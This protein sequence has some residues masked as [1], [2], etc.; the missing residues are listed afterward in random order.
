M[1]R[2]L[3]RALS[4]VMS[5]AIALSLMVFVAPV[6]T[7]AEDYSSLPGYPD[8]PAKAF[9]GGSPSATARL[10][11]LNSPGGRPWQDPSLPI[12]WRVQLLVDCMTLEEKAGQTIQLQRDATQSYIQT[13]YLGSILSGGGSVPSPNTPAGWTTMMNNIQN[14]AAATPLQIPVLYQIDA[15]H[16]TGHMN[17]NNAGAHTT[18]Y[19]HNYQAANIAGGITDLSSPKLQSTIQ[20]LKDYYHATAEEMRAIGIQGS[21]SP[22]VCTP[23]NYRWGRTHE[24]WNNDPLYNGIMAAAC[25]EGMQGGRPV[26]YSA[27]NTDYDHPNQFPFLS[28]PD[29]AIVCMKHF[30]GEGYT[31]NGANTGNMIIPSLPTTTAALKALTTEQLKAMPIIQELLVPYKLLVEAGARCFMP[32]YSSIN[33]LKM[34]EFGPMQDL[35]K[36]PKSEGG[37]GFTGFVVSDYNAHTNG[38]TG[39]NQAARN[40]NCFNAGVDLAMVVSA[41]ECTSATGWYQTMISNVNSGAVTVARL[42]DAV[43]RIL[44]VKFEQGLFDT[45]GGVQF[46]KARANTALQAT[47]R[48][49]EHVALAR[50]MVRESLVLLKNDPS[51]WDTLQTVPPNQILVAGT[52]A[53]DIGYQVGSWVASWQGGSSTN[54]NTYNGRMIIDAV[55]DAKGTGVLYNASG[56]VTGTPADVKVAIVCIGETSYAEGSGDQT[57]ITTASAAATLQFNDTYLAQVQSVKTNY[58]NAK[59]IV[60]MLSG[61][62]MVISGW[63]DSVDAIIMC[64]WFGTEAGG[65][66]DLLFDPN[67][68]FTGRSAWAWP[69]G[70]QTLGDMS[71]PPLFPIGFGL[72]KNQETPPLVR[73]D[74]QGA[75]ININASGNTS[76]SGTIYTQNSTTGVRTYNQKVYWKEG[77]ISSSTLV[78]P[79]TRGAMATG[80]RSTYVEYKLYIQRP[81]AYTFGYTGSGTSAGGLTLSMDGGDGVTFNAAASVSGVSMGNLTPGEHIMRITFNTNTAMTLTTLSVTAPGGAALTTVVPEVK[82]VVAGFNANIPVATNAE[83]GAI[84]K[85][86]KGSAVIGEAIVAD[87]KAVVALKKADLS[88]AGTLNAVVYVEGE[89]QIA[90]PISVVAYDPS[91]WTVKI[92]G[93][94]NSILASFNANID[95]S[96]AAFD[97]KVNGVSV[98]GAKTSVVGSDGKSFVINGAQIDFLNSGDEF[99]I[100]GVRLPDMFPDYTFT[101]RAVLVK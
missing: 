55:R 95:L 92:S 83:D 76:W 47:I 39:A 77:Y 72:T 16:G 68:D 62:P 67:Y 31:Y 5:V 7:S 66:A 30:F 54:Y 51:I 6:S 21:F 78:S 11:A 65:V 75:P 32:S 96:S 93:T 43:S 4:L 57:N 3:R 45:I 36:K 81:G 100:I 85:I 20:L 24:G 73:P 28:E 34:H 19:P 44:R 60:L 64:G 71:Q 40:A 87:G 80:G 27:L 101:Y 69:A 82:S 13:Y 98:P 79:A 26:D 53:Q 89:A 84:V 61:R 37:L 25:T 33:G 97:V 90:S 41:S 94:S 17:S 1:K 52:F 88:A 58:P 29:T 18:L 46:A 15:V 12:E 63:Y 86:E 50:K 56:G 48:S 91:V 99:E 70:P 49:P 8:N 59:V 10:A 74:L 23:Q 2:F 9:A 22:A 38:I 35:I 42:N 14:Y